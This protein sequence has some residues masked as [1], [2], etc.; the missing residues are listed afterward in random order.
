MRRYL[1]T[2]DLH[3]VRDYK[4][5]YQL[6][7][8]WK[9]V[10]LTE[11]LWMAVLKGPAGTVRNFVRATLDGDDTVAVVEIKAGSDWATQNATPA[12]NAWLAANVT[13]TQKAA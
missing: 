12:A 1:I 2:Y 7:A 6:M 13:P 3:K 8:T 4:K 11:S 5:L 9:A 10:R